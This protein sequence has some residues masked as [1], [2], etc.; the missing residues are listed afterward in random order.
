MIIYNSTS[1]FIIHISRN[2]TYVSYE[3]LDTI[4]LGMSHGINIQLEGLEI[5]HISRIYR[6]TAR[7]SW[8]AGDPRIDWVLITQRAERCHGAL[9]GV[10][11]WQQQ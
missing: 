1:R 3:Q 2:N 10:V 8:Y 7:Q 6:Y 11:L 4:K 9:N 5:E